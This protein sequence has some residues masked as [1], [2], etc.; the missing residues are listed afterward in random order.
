MLY[1]LKLF[2]RQFVFA[3][4]FWILACTLFILI[5]FL[6]YGEDQ[7]EIYANPK[8]QV[9]I[10]E[11]IHYGLIAGIMVGVSY[12]I[13][14]FLFEKFI[15]KNIYLGLAVIFKIFLYIFV[16][17]FTLTFVLRLIELEMDIDLP[18]QRGWWIDNTIFWL[19]S[20][21]FFIT[22]F[23]FLFI[24]IANEKFGK[25]V[26]FNM[27]I[28]KYRKPTEED[29]IFMFLD[30]KASTTIA[31]KMGHNKYS[32]LLQ[33]CFFDLN[34]IVDR[35][36]GEIYQYVGDEAVISWP[37]KKG[38]RHNNCIALY[39]A[40]R[41]LL[42]KRQKY[43]NRNYGLLPFF[44]A[45]LHGGRLIITEVGVVK[46]ELAFHGDVINTTAR[47]QDECNKYNESLL[48]SESLLKEV[49]FKSKYLI[50][51]IGNLEL[52][53]KKESIKVFAINEK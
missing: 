44:K 33:D 13:I 3:N 7:G 22:S 19:A 25:G 9:P 34:K 41:K 28:G 2:F 39:F 24:K 53:G 4:V 14:E 38:L 45:G 31:E 17:I 20:S 8:N 42:K 30:L 16:L 35:Y 26:L 29:R 48:I 5:R 15:T 50:N 6:A 47:I 10:T 27:L 51:E 32:Q 40:F 37:I 11:W 21:Y 52:K 1:N 18:N 12:A 23:L 46:K 49:Y 36:S 43:Y